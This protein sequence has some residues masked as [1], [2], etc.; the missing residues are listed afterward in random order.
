MQYIKQILLTIIIGFVMVAGVSMV[1]ATGPTQNPPGGNTPAPVNVGTSNQT[2]DGSKTLQFGS[3]S[4][5]ILT[6]N[7]GVGILGAL[8]SYYSTNLAVNSGYNVGIGTANPNSSYKLDVNGKINGTELCINGSC[9]ASWPSGSGGTITGSGATGYLARW[10]GSSA[11]GRSNIFEYVQPSS[12]SSV[13]INKTTSLGSLLALDIGGNVSWEGYELK[14]GT[15]PWARLTGYPSAC[16]SGQYVSS[17]NNFG[18]T[19]STPTDTKGI[20]SINGMTGSSIA[21]VPGSGISTQNSGGT[22]TIS[23]T[24]TTPSLSCYSPTSTGSGS[25]IVTCPSGYTLTGGGCDSVVV[26]GQDA[27]NALIYN[28]PSGNGWK[29]ANNKS[30]NVTVYA[31]CCKLQ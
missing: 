25:K 2:F 7:G 10:T 12:N 23:N 11:L 31:V 17:F 28:S 3:S 1:S 6:L 21:I 13:G 8:N 4:S 14:G 16:S 22:V 5:G 30:T 20:T 18:L 26:P 29:C 9:N 27:W 19:C 24:H 15:V